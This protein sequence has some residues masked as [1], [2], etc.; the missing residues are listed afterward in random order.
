MEA[1]DVILDREG[2]H[3]IP[4]LR[5]CEVRQQRCAVLH[6]EGK[7]VFLGKQGVRPTGRKR[8]QWPARAQGVT[9]EAT[10]LVVLRM[11]ARRARCRRPPLLHAAHS[12]HPSGAAPARGASSMRRRL[13]EGLAAGWEWMRWRRS[14]MPCS[15]GLRP[16]PFCRASKAR[17]RQT[18]GKW[19][20]RR[21]KSTQV[22]MRF[23]PIPGR[24][25]PPCP[26]C[27]WCPRCASQ[28]RPSSGPSRASEARGTHEAHE[29]HTRHMVEQHGSE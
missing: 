14:G 21:R 16:C 12:S 27:P 2:R 1:V 9:L 24:K 28:S 3:E 5:I 4:E 13:G 11:R 17:E 26:R 22:R 20:R 8:R 23:S 6:R 19:S 18:R 10:H 15:L 7:E 29:A 25:C